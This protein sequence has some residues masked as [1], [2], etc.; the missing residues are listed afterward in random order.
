MA[1][2]HLLRATLALNPAE[3]DVVLRQDVMELPLLGRW[4][5]C[6]TLDAGRS[7]V[8]KSRGASGLRPLRE[9]PPSA[10][11]SLAPPSPL[12]PACEPA[13]ALRSPALAT[14]RCSLPY[15]VEIR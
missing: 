6:L 7:P 15:P 11:L 9:C 4:A 5:G 3:V 8:P 1:V 13:L 12:R 10:N 14:G 2:A